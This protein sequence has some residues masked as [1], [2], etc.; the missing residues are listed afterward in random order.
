MP[1][2]QNLRIGD[3]D[4]NKEIPKPHVFLCKPDGTTISK[5]SE[6]YD[7]SLST[8]LSVVNQLSFKIPT[9]IEKDR[10]FVHNFHIDMLKPRYL[11]RFVIN[12]KTEYFVLTETSKNLSSNGK[13]IQYDVYGLGYELI[14]KT[15]RRLEMNTKP[16]REIAEAILENTL[17]Q[18][19]YIDTAFTGK[20]MNRT[21]EITSQTALQGVYDL[22]KMYNALITW[23]TIN[24]KISFYSPDRIGSNKGLRINDRR[25][26]ET[27]DVKI[28]ATETITRLK[29]YG[30]DNIQITSVNPKGV[31]YIEDYRWYLHPFE[32]DALGNIVKSSDYFTDDMSLALIAYEEL[33]ELHEG[34]FN[35]LITSANAIDEILNDKLQELVSLK[36]QLKIAWD[37]IDV[38]NASVQ[39]DNTSL[40]VNPLPSNHWELVEEKDRL[41]TLV[42]NKELEILTYEAQLDDI[43]DDISAL[44]DLLSRDN[45]FTPSQIEQLIQFTIEKEYNESSI[46][47][48]QDL[49]DESQKVFKELSK[50]KITA[51]IGI[52]NLL[53]VIEAQHDWHK[54]NLGDTV[55]IKDEDLEFDISA[56]FTEI[57]YDFENKSISLV[58]ANELDE[59]DDIL[60]H[61]QNGATGNAIIQ[62][63]KWDWNL[64]K[65]NNGKINDIINNKWDAEKNAIEAGYEQLITI[66][67]RGII[68]ESPDEPCKSV[69]IQAGRIALTQDCGNTW[70]TAINPDGI[71]AEYLW[72]KVI[73]GVNLII[74][75]ESGVWITQGS[76]TT[77]YNRHSEEVMRLGL[78]TEPN[79]SDCFGIKSWNDVTQVEMTDCVG[80]AIS[81]WDVEKD[82]WQKVLWA[83]P[84]GTLATKNMVAEGIKIVNNLGETILDAENQ[85]LDW[86]A[87]QEILSDLVITPMEKTELA[88]TLTEMH[89]LFS[90]RY[91]QAQEHYYSSRNAT[92]DFNGA[93]N[94]YSGTFP[95]V[96]SAEHTGNDAVY[97]G[98]FT[99]LSKIYKNN[100]DFFFQYLSYQNNTIPKIKPIGGVMV[101]KDGYVAKDFIPESLIIEFG[102]TLMN[103]NS[104]ITNEER[105]L[106]LYWLKEFF[107]AV[108]EFD[109]EL[110]DMI[111]YSGLQ[112]GRFYNNLIMDKHGFIA[113]RNDGRYRAFMNATHGLA[114]QRWENGQWVSKLYATLGHPDWEDGTLYAEGLVTKN[115][116]IVDGELGEAIVLDHKTGITIYGRNGEV[117]KL[118]ANEAISIYTNG[119]RKFWVGTDGRLYAKD[120]TTHNLKIVNGE[121][122]EKIILDENDGITINGNNGEQIRLNAN[123]GIAIDVNGDKRI[124]LGNDGLMYAKK[125]FIMGDDEDEIIEDIDGSYISDL[126]VNRLKTLGNEK[127]P[128]DIVHIEQNYLKLKSWTGVGEVNKFTLFLNNSG[129][130]ASYPETHWGSGDLAQGDGI[131]VGKIYKDSSKFAFEYMSPLTGLSKI[132]FNDTDSDNE[133]QAIYIHSG[134]GIRLESE[135]KVVMKT[136]D[137]QYIRITNG[138]DIKMNFGSGQLEINQTSFTMKFGNSKIELS[139]S[140]VKINGSR[141]DLN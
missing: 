67:E 109:R 8:K 136:T 44:N 134:G 15:H 57:T 110:T 35:Q 5:I 92:Y 13:Y 60:K 74:E 22:A 103:T 81:K 84:D 11:I 119:D 93:F 131:E 34:E 29:P 64:S 127:T 40:N 3:I 59:A 48:P 77:I 32:T 94:P 14:D 126:T 63:D 71:W 61:I 30:K 26:L 17:W 123:E 120:I 140:G 86:G 97:L 69:I 9:K 113:V 33:V 24:R 111:F 129:G 114:L 55:R 42:Q 45:N 112:M 53:E 139:S 36:T 87:L 16:M 106:L 54:L 6:S 118:N 62:H 89:E 31:P 135:N 125:L 95:I 25:F 82:D 121:L 78:V 70:K 58:I 96:Q 7:I 47:D 50:P 91:R 46:D 141:I 105:R 52:V 90:T 10:A 51:R 12:R 132:H 49:Y 2:S 38:S 27:A 72:G 4:Y 56:K 122:G 1:F 99:K 83:M 88:K 107:N 28:D 41:E 137:D 138:E 66:N 130:G 21:F 115:L 98:S 85:M 73:S 37:K 79:E 101:D 116:R 128:Q 23:D 39:I 76:R 124:W 43:D 102:T 65:E 80:M 19:D 100:L 75:D 68:V 108:K 133:K 117:I 18:V 104:E 20:G